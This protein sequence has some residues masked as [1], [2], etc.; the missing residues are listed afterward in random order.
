MEQ[1]TLKVLEYDAIIEMLKSMAS[2]ELGKIRAQKIYPKN[3][4]EEIKGLLAETS[5][6]QSILLK[7]GNLPIS[8]IGD[9]KRQL[10]LASIGSTVDLGGILKVG[11]IL[12]TSRNVKKKLSSLTEIPIIS[13]M[14]SSLYIAIDLET[15]IFDSIISEDE[16]SDNA[17]PALKKIRRDIKNTK[18]Q[19]RVKISSIA[20]SEENSK[21]LQDSIVTMR[22]DRFVVPVKAE[23]RSSIPGIVHDTSSSGATLFV[24]PMAVVEMNN[25]LRILM[26]KEKEEIERIIIEFSQDIGEV[27]DEIGINQDVLTELDYI[28]AKG[29]LS[30]KMKA[31]EPEL[32]PNM[33]VRLKNARHPLI[34]PK[35]VVPMNLE[36]GKEYNTLVVTGPN[37]GGKT[38]SLKTM[39]LLSLM[40]QSGLHVPCDY[41]T[42]MF[43]YN[44]VFADIGDEQSIEQSLSTFS[45]HMT[46]IVKI[47]AEVKA[48]DLVL[49]DELGSGTDPIEG[50]ALAISILEKLMEYDLITMATTHYSELKNFALNTIGVE[51][52]SVEFDVE[53]LSPTYRLI[54]GI[55]GKSNAFDI[56]KKLGLSDA[57]IQDAKRKLKAEDIEMEDILRKLDQ[58]RLSIEK[59]REYLKTATD[60]LK[61][62]LEDAQNKIEKTKKDREK[63]LTDAKRKASNILRD[64]KVESEGIIKEL[65]KLKTEAERNQTKKLEAIRGKL[66]NNLDKYGYTEEL[67]TI[68]SNDTKVKVVTEGMMVFVSSFGQEGS[69]V[70][71]DDSKKEALIQI[72]VMRINIPYDALSVPKK[73][74]APKKTGVGKIYK[75]KAMTI[76]SEV[77]VRGMDLETAR[78]EVEKYL[79]NAYLSGIPRV[80]VIHGVGTLVLK[81]GISEFMRNLHYV[82][83]FRGGEYGEGGAGVTIVEFK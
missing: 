83:S 19:I 18:E 9:V 31:M 65:N 23:N 58:D 22:G 28:M 71:K 10:K 74:A 11:R 2:T 20:N 64:A 50:S 37:T 68:E 47:L 4:I 80:T 77:D 54:T 26:V 15:R 49:L 34:D 41:G 76:K 55:P 12:N 46:H 44:N 48:Q 25:N 81:R 45:S 21:Y 7:Q 43:V 61:F 30:V 75:E 78:I 51:N 38:V 60:E 40:M 8:S 16:M 42:T 72:G 57:I 62:K 27:A 13:A 53:T 3:N 14:A 6:A 52:A 79:D 36:V 5:E 24:E 73:K 82:K 1:K 17:S 67:L 32:S 29:K 59:D 66:R 63:A 35:V 39:G 33:Y 56:S 69:V 70:S